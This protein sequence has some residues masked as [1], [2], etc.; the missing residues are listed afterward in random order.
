[1]LSYLKYHM[2]KNVFKKV[3]MYTNFSRWSYC[4]NL[5]YRHIVKEYAR[6]LENW[7]CENAFLQQ[8]MSI[9]HI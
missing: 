5:K 9:P 3:S 7:V 6:W 1:M 4:I 8:T 2:R